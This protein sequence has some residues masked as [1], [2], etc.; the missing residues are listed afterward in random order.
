MSEEETLGENYKRAKYDDVERE[1][2]VID[3]MESLEILT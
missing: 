3:D 1:Q 2:H